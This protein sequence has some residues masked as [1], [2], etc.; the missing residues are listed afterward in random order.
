MLLTRRVM[1]QKLTLALRVVWK[2]TR[3]QHHAA[4]GSNTLFFAIAHHHC[5][6][7]FAV[8]RDQSHRGR[9]DSDLDTFVESRF[10]QPCNQCIAIDKVHASAR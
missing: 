1:G 6:T 3:G 7:N 5:A 9:V 8:L 10:G 2:A 4:F